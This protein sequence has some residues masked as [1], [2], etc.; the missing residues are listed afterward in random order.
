V[1]NNSHSLKK[2]KMPVLIMWGKKDGWINPKY[3]QSF[4]SAIPQ[5][6]LITFPLLGHIPMEESPRETLKPTLLFLNQ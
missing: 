3:A 2:L 6:K 1:E 5:S 4:H